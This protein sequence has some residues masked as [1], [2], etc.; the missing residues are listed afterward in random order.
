MQ[1]MGGYFFF[2]QTVGMGVPS[3]HDI[4]NINHA[5]SESEKKEGFFFRFF[6]QF[7][8]GNRRSLASSSVARRVIRD[9]QP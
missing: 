6:F 5:F 7:F 1:A 9:A 4:F 3:E 2:L 8:F